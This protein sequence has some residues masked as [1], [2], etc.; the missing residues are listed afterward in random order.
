[1]LATAALDQHLQSRSVAGRH[2][3]GL[4]SCELDLHQRPLLQ[5]VLFP[6]P[7]AMRVALQ[8]NQE[9]LDPIFQ[10]NAES[11]R[12]PKNRFDQQPTEVLPKQ[13]L[14]PEWRTNPRL[15]TSRELQA[16]QRPLR[17]FAVDDWSVPKSPCHQT[18]CPRHVI[19]TRH[20]Q[21]TFDRWLDSL[22]QIST[23]QLPG[24]FPASV[25]LDSR[26]LQTTEKTKLRPIAPILVGYDGCWAVPCVSR[27]SHFSKCHQPV[28]GLYHEI[29]RSPAWDRQPNDFLEIDDGVVGRS[30]IAVD[31]CPE[32]HLPK[33]DRSLQ[34]VEPPVIRHRAV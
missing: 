31:W 18:G 30:P 32:I 19:G 2:P 7:L 23:F 21:V 17:W 9:F 5:H 3:K 15:P 20:N 12:R 26:R 33:Q 25:A 4:D 14:P 8:S 11:W 34:I 22:S 10:P 16:G 28:R 13:S 6:L 29:R 1:M 24:P 27:P